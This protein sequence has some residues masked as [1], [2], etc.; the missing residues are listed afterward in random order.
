MPETPVAVCSEAWLVRGSPCAKL[1]APVSFKIKSSA[2][3]APVW[4]AIETP[5]SKRS[6]GRANCGSSGLAISGWFETNV[7][8]AVAK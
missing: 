4:L 2:P 1:S 8:S 3:A 7:A 6:P 5:R